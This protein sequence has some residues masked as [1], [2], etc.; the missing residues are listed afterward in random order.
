MAKAKKKETTVKKKSKNGIIIIIIAAIFVSILTVVFA[1]IVL[2]PKYQE[3]KTNKNKEKIEEIATRKKEIGEIFEMEPFTINPL[4]SGG[5]RFAKIQLSL[6]TSN[7]EVIEELTKRKPQIKSIMLKYF[8][9]KTILELTHPTFTD[10]S[11]TVL[12]DKVN[13]V[14]STGKVTNLFYQDLL[15][16]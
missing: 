4:N 9:S 15:I 2:W 11:A 8:R 1:K 16:Q 7:K 3:I 12:I 6:E 14:L 13:E 10:S 5:R